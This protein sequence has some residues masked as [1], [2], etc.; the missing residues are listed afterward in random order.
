MSPKYVRLVDRRDEL[1]RKFEKGDVNRLFYLKQLGALTLKADKLARR[2]VPD[3][4]EAEEANTEP[5]A[6]ANAAGNAEANATAVD[7]DASIDSMSETRLDPVESE[8]SDVNQEDP[9]SMDPVLQLG[10]R[11]AREKK[12]A[13]KVSKKRDICPECKRGFQMRRIPPLHMTCFGCEVLVHTRCVKE[14]SFC[15]KCRKEDIPA[16][17]G[18]VTA[19]AAPVHG[20]SKPSHVPADAVPVERAVQ[21]SCC[22]ELLLIEDDN[23]SFESSKDIFDVRMAGLGFVRSPTQPDTLGDGNC[24]I[25]ALLDQL[26]SDPS[27]MFE[28]GDEVLARFV[29]ISRISFPLSLNFSGSL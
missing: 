19:A 14:D 20:P 18:P 3:Q 15:S 29:S 21:D 5:N 26:S 10:K 9:F 12:N 7:S 17:G 25:Y 27:P 2:L 16:S 22:D 24:G 13:P 23:P 6:E 11:T 28:V 4:I 1:M 8:D